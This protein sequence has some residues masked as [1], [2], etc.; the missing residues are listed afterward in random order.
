MARYIDAEI[1]KKVLLESA[2]HQLR[3]DHIADAR[4]LKYAADVVGRIE[5]ADV[6]PVRH[7]H[8]KYLREEKCAFCTA[9]KSK[10][11]P[12]LYGYGF[13]PLCGARMDGKENEK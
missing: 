8:W 4:G 7:G 9:C 2:A 3:L 1:A 12:N 5:T 11:N 6:A 13:C 10:M